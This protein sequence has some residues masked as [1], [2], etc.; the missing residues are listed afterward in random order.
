M[1]SPVQCLASEIAGLLQDH[2]ARLKIP[3]ASQLTL[4][5]YYRILP[6]HISAALQQCAMVSKL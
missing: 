1:S 2:Q 5:S 4:E 3:K 6:Q